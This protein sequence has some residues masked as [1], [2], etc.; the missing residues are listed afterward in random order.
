[1]ATETGYEREP[2]GE[3]RRADRERLVGSVLA[4]L[5]RLAAPGGAADL[6]SEAALTE[7]D[8]LL[9]HLVL[10]PAEGGP[11]VDREVAYTLGVTLLARAGARQDAAAREADARTGLLLLGPFHCHP[12]DSPDVLAPPLRAR[13]DEL[14]GTG[15]PEDRGAVVRAHAAALADLGHLL[16]R[17]GIGLSWTQ[18]LEACAELTRGAL[19]HLATEGPARAL[20][21][22]NLGYALLILSHGTG[23]GTGKG[24]GSETDDGTGNGTGDGTGKGTGDPTGDGTRS[25]TDDGTGDGTGNRTGEGAGNETGDGTGKGT[26]DPTGEGAGEGTEEGAGDGAGPR[27][28]AAG[29]RT[30]GGRTGHGRLDEAADVFRTAYAATPPDHPNHARCANGLA[31]T[32]LGIAA[33]TEDR[34]RLPEVI[35]LLRTAT[36][37]A[38]PADGNAA[39]MYSDL[40]HVLTLYARGAERAQDMSP[41]VREEAV[42]A[43]RRA[44]DLTPAEDHA[45][46]RTHLDRL[47]EA[48]LIGAARAEPARAAALAAEAAEA[49]RRLLG[50]T[51]QGHPDRE[52]VRLRLAVH[53]VAAGRLVDGIALLAAADPMF[54]G[55]A[56]NA[57]NTGDAGN[58][59]LIAEAAARVRADAFRPDEPPGASALPPGLQ[60]DSDAVDAIVRDAMSGADPGHPVAA[61]LDL[62]GM[63]PQGGNGARGQELTDLAGLVVG[64]PGQASPADILERG[65]ELELRRLARLPE[66]ERVRALAAVLRGGTGEPEPPEPVDTG[67]LGEILAVYDRLLALAAPGSRTH[68]LLRSGRNGLA[69]MKSL[70]DS[71]NLR[72]GDPARLDLVR[73]TLPQLRELYEELPRQLTDLG[74][75]PELFAGQVALSFAEESPFERIQALEDGIRA[76]RRRLAGLSPGTGEYDET[77][78]T[79]AVQLFN[80]HLMWSEET[81]YTE[82]EAL[83]R[84]LTATTE[85]DGRSALLLHRWA[86]AVHHRLDNGRRFGAGPAGPG[87]SPSLV[88][89]LASDAAARALDRH[90]P[91]D[92][93]ETLE[94]GRAHL[95]STALNARREL[96]ALHGA[97]AALHARLRTA[98]DRLRAVRRSME[99]GRRPTPEETTEQRAVLDR[100]AR[101]ITELKQRPGFQRFLTPLPLA[102]ADLRPAAAE[103]P[104]VSVNVHPR[105]CDALVLR[106]EG[107]LTVPLPRLAAADLTAQA[108]ALRPALAALMA[109]PRDPLYPGARD[110]FTGTLAWLWDVLAEPVLDALDFSGPPAPGAPWPRLWWAPSGVLNSFPLHA[111]GHHGPGAP[112]G[113]AV[114]DRVAS[115]YTPTLRALLYSRARRRAAPGRRGVVAVAMPETPGQVPLPRTV[116]EAAAALAA[117]GGTPLTGPDATRAA[118]RDALLDA[119]VV[120]FACHA[121]S[122]PEDVTAGRL[123]L[124]DGD[125]YVG[126]LAGLRLETAELAYL[127]ACGTAR[128]G[129]APPFADEV[130]HLASVFQLAGYTQSVATL[131]EVGDAFAARAAAAFHHALAPSLPSPAPLPAALALH[132]TVRTL[133]TADPERPWTWGALVHAGA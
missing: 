70:Q 109:G 130:I 101:L 12:P 25:G 94:D 62:L 60:A 27:R 80:R 21:G 51:P 103:G 47:A 83:T 30:R 37:S 123:M 13:L 6:L 66:A 107:V 120:H 96:A 46:L 44:L 74:F 8:A 55:N 78:T 69:V 22:C 67:L 88:I 98:L 35:D 59:R 15:R 93:L 48:A 99:P 129:T 124:A 81:D 33:R 82:A 117:T 84:A 125:L 38:G 71:Q 24:T 132:D 29:R 90:D 73:G 102:L 52:G 31:L 32:L 11:G 85:P 91:V 1:M 72:E 133:R 19:P 119:A 20:A 23:D 104:V 5:D 58:A 65:A 114:L 108:E 75:E 10:T 76:C 100:A 87:R 77:R 4:R 26:G 112:A 122:D 3:G 127:S 110:I 43:L 64:H 79:L 115:S 89:R 118:V 28:R 106:P 17:L 53:L 97:D 56:G 131:W 63:G 50:L 34:T 16:L 41:E 86:A 92:A 61:V 36:R 7:A 113:A 105:R 57:G 95:L 40:G 9:S 18:A 54:A 45:A 49:L 42:G 116:A 126:E 39:Q 2:A 111:A 128:A 121:G 14:L 68:R